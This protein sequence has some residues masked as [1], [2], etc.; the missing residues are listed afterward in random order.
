MSQTPTVFI[1]DDDQAVRDSLRLLLSSAEL[2][3]ETFA[4]AREFLEAVPED[5]PGCLVL[6]IR[7]PETDGLELQQTLAR[8]GS[9]MPIIILTGHGDVPMAVQALRAGALDFF[10]KPFESKLL[11]SR[12]EEAI[13]LDAKARSQQTDRLEIE[14]RLA[15]LTPRENEVLNCIVDGMPTKAIAASLGSSFN[16]VQNQRASILRKIQAESVADLVRMVMIARAGR[17]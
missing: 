3:S 10:Q 15:R 6:D 17:R 4:G 2:P 13:A 16:T 5:R 7:M 14:S 11:L 1:V 9:R 8:R 12:I